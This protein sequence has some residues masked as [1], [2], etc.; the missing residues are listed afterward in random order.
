MTAP[1]FNYTYET[2]T[3]LV[4]N[5]AYGFGTGT[6]ANYYSYVAWAIKECLTDPTLTSPWIIDGS[7]DADGNSGM[8]G[9]DRWTDYTKVRDNNSQA[10]IVCRQPGLNGGAQFS[11]HMKDN[12]PYKNNEAERYLAPAGGMTDW[13]ASPNGLVSL[14]TDSNPDE[15]WWIDDSNPSAGIT[16]VNAAIATNGKATFFWCWR[17]NECIM[18]GMFYEPLNYPA[19]WTLPVVGW[20]PDLVNTGYPANRVA[21]MC[22]GDDEARA[23]WMPDALTT[24]DG[25]YATHG[26]GGNYLY[27]QSFMRLRSEFTAEWPMFPMHLTD[28]TTATRGM[29]GQVPDLY[30]A[31]AVDIVPDGSTSSAMDWIKVG[32]LWVPWDGSTVPVLR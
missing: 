26:Y 25:L 27:N 22:N 12:Y 17:F 15:Y 29:Y 16:S 13:N 7:G 30:F 20:W 4:D 18:F 19:G 8:D 5:T 14:N 24:A 23:K 6:A 28:S 9:V 11:F 31:Q 32:D 2:R 10:W 1:V 3:I 21:M